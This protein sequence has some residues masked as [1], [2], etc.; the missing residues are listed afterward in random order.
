VA[1][2]ALHAGRISEL[3][4]ILVFCLSSKQR[5]WIYL[6]KIA[7]LL[8]TRRKQFCAPPLDLISAAERVRR[9]HSR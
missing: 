4:T 2:G 7:L 1:Q 9:T 5:R 6:I 8:I 3:R